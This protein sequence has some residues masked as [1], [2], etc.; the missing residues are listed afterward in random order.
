MPVRL[1]RTDDLSELMTI[2]EAATLTGRQAAT[3]RSWIHR[4]HLR[5]ALKLRG[6]V[7]VTE[8][9]V[10]DAEAAAAGFPGVPGDPA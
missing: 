4:G 2:A 10:V 7:Y 5:V 8:R 9:Q 6:R 3:I 1:D